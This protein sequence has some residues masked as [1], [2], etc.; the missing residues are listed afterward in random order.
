MLTG[1]RKVNDP[2]EALLMR[3]QDNVEL[4]LN[5]IIG[6]RILDGIILENITIST[7]VDNKV[8]HKLSRKFIGWIIVRNNAE[9]VVYEST[10]VNNIPEKQIILNASADAIISIYI[11]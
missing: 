8:N 11:F 7:G 3:L 2:Q 6:N 9:S 10:T 1:F 4:S 5:Q